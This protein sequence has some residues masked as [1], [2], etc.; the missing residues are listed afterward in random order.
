MNE[1]A[2]ILEVKNLARDVPTKNGPKTIVNDISY[3]FEKGRIYNIMGPSGAGKSSFLRLINRLDEPT[4]GQVIFHGENFN[5]CPACGLR[6]KIGYLFQTPYLFPG[7][8]RDNLLYAEDKLTEDDIQ[9]LVKQSRIPPGIIDDDVENLSI[10][11]KQRVALA[12]LLAMEPEIILLDEPTSALDPTYTKAIEDLI[13]CIVKERS[14]TVIMVTHHPE[15]ALRMGGQALLLVAGRLVETG[16]VDE[17]VKNPKTE[18]GRRYRD[19]EMQ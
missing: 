17:V 15:Q 11:E 7:T 10:G 14:L 4:R 8:V 6:R 19:M 16:T 12:R 3:N 18:M 1:T 13:K 9:R 5:Q 2:A